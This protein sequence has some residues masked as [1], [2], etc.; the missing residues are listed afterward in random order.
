[1]I[2]KAFFGSKLDDFGNTL[3]N[4][5]CFTDSD[6]IIKYMNCFSPCEKY[7]VV[8]KLRANEKMLENDGWLIREGWGET[9][10][11]ID[12]KAGNE[13]NSNI[14]NAILDNLYFSEIELE[15]LNIELEKIKEYFDSRDINS[16]NKWIRQRSPLL[17]NIAK[18]FDEFSHV[19]I[20]ELYKF[21][22]EKE[23]ESI[24]DI[25]VF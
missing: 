7:A 9:K 18:I 10:T 8:T 24:D 6:D 17:K 11:D 20:A 21:I 4:Y 15:N 12:E 1:M 22:Q 23:L 13:P 3:Y 19:E 14:R 25:V 5:A 2:Y 16:S